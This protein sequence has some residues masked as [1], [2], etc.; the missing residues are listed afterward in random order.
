M[1]IAFIIN[2]RRGGISRMTFFVAVP[3]APEE[4]EEEA[5]GVDDDVAD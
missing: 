4:E 3:A 5:A 1:A 2:V